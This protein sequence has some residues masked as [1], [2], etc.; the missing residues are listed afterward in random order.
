MEKEEKSKDKEVEKTYIEWE[1]PEHDYNEKSS[2][3]LWIT[4]IITMAMFF[5]SIILG[6]ILFGLIILLSGFSITMHAVKKPDI[7]KFKIGPH[8]IQIKDRFF[9]YKNLESFW[10]NYKD[11]NS[12]NS[13]EVGKELLIKTKKTLSST[14]SVMTG[15]IDPEIIEDYLSNFLVIEEI[16]KPLHMSITE[17]LKI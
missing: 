4:A 15:E 2:D 8:G 17:I 9:D 16:D 1:A 11:D 13:N 3:W 14:L 7:I 6:N 5:V 10:I 12:D